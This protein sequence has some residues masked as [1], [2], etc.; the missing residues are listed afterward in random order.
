MAEHRQG[1]P[2]HGCH[3]DDHSDVD[4]HID[5]DEK[6]DPSR[7]GLDEIVLLVDPG[8]IE[9]VDDQQDI[10]GDDREHPF[11]AE[12]FPQIG[13]DEVTGGDGEE[14][15]LGLG[16]LLLGFAL[17]ASGTDGDEGLADVVAGFAEEVTDPLFLIVVEV[18][19]E[20]RSGKSRQE[21]NSKPDPPAYPHEKEHPVARQQQ[22]HRGTE[23]GLFGDEEEGDNDDDRELEKVFEAVALFGRGITVDQI[24]QHQQDADLDEF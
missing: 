20:H 6:S 16:R 9:Q 18:V 10:E 2:H 8:E 24:S 15:E 11:E 22:D 1:D 19:V 3:T 23:I 21:Q 5:E 12:A 14:F 7:D 17:Q 13:E 4:P